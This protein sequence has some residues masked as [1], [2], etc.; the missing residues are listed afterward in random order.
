MLA[1]FL[2]VTGIR[3]DHAYNAVAADDFAVTANFLYRR[4]YSHVSSFRYKRAS[5]LLRTEH[6][7]SSGQV[8]TSRTRSNPAR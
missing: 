7:P 3:A 2:L 1:L 4:L 6:D 5:A 8:A